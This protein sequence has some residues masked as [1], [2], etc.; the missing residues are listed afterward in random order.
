MR[1]HS[2]RMH[3]SY[4]NEIN[5]VSRYRRCRRVNVWMLGFAL[6]WLSETWHDD[7]KLV[8]NCTARSRKNDVVLRWGDGVLREREWLKTRL[9]VSAQHAP[10]SSPLSR[11]TTRGE[12]GR[13]G[14]GC[15]L[16]FRSLKAGGQQPVY[17][18]K[19]S[20]WAC[21]KLFTH[22]ESGSTSVF[23]LEAPLRGL[24]GWLVG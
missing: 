6:Q 23:S 18:G 1:V 10:A 14:P 17:P 20:L 12:R 13:D 9:T 19:S 21:Y 22:T 11:Q 5:K 7:I 3:A 2:H 15:A 4:I 16:P 8:S 24:R